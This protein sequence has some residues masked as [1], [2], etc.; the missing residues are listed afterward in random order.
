MSEEGTY[1][2]KEGENRLRRGERER[3]EN[4]R[5]VSPEMHGAKTIEFH[6]GLPA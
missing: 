6:G 4:I 1:K 5:V 2:E 3:D